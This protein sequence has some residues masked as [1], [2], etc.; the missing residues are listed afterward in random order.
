MKKIKVF[1]GRRKIVETIENGK[2]FL[3]EVV[4]WEPVVVN[5]VENKKEIPTT[6][7]ECSRLDTRGTGVKFYYCNC[8]EYYRECDMKNVEPET[9]ILNSL[10]ELGTPKEV[11]LSSWRKEVKYPKDIFK[12]LW[13]PEKPAWEVAFEYKGKPYVYILKGTGK[14]SCR[15]LTSWEIQNKKILDLS[16]DEALKI[17]EKEK[18]GE[19][20][21]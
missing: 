8:E 19:K 17:I 2:K 9:T 10:G 16:R 12:I 15:E 1:L 21:F 20:I 6:C 14:G 7:R 4:Y 18:R 11:F 5:I 13:V 3:D